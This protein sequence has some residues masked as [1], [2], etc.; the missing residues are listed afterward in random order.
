RPSSAGAARN[1]APRTRT[2]AATRST[3]WRRI[4]ARRATRRR[5]GPRS[6]TSSSITLRT[7]TRP[8]LGPSSAKRRLAERARMDP[9]VI[10]IPD[11]AYPLE[12]TCAVVVAAASALAPGELAV[13]LRHKSLVG[14][15]LE[16][17]ARTVGETAA[18]A[19]ARFVLSAFTAE[20][21]ALATKL[22]CD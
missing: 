13:Q 11:P 3:R 7:V 21:I 14:A 12:R 2:R 9:I 18:R 17:A 5:R 1:R 19:G 22:G 15:E 8:R 4:S 10:L 20:R 16:G 6:A